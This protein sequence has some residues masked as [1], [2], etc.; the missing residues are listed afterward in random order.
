MDHADF[1]H[2]IGDGGNVTPKFH[3]AVNNDLDLTWLFR[4][5]YPIPS[6][7]KRRDRL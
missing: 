4:F 5:T 7:L 1:N 6:E 3:F 2:W